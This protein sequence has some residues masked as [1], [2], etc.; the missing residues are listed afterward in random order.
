VGVHPSR[1]LR[2]AKCGDVFESR[3]GLSNHKRVVTGCG[4]CPDAALPL[5]LGCNRCDWKCA[6]KDILVAHYEL[7]HAVG[8]YEGQRTA[9]GNDADSGDDAHYG[10]ENLDDNDPDDVSLSVTEDDDPHVFNDRDDDDARDDVSLSVAEKDDPHVFYDLDDDD[11]DDN[12]VSG[13]VDN[14]FYV[15]DD[16]DAVGDL[17]LQ[18]KRMATPVGAT[19]DDVAAATFSDKSGDYDRKMKDPLTFLPSQRDELRLMNLVV[20]KNLPDNYYDE[21]LGVIKNMETDPRDGLLRSSKLVIKDVLSRNEQG[22]SANTIVC[23]LEAPIGGQTT[24]EFGWTGIIDNLKQMLSDP[25]LLGQCVGD[26]KL[27]LHAEDP[28]GENETVSEMNQAH[29]WR[30][31]EEACCHDD[32]KTILGVVT[33]FI[34]GTHCDEHGRIKLVPIIMMCGNYPKKLNRKSDFMRCLGYLPSGI[35]FSSA[36]A[37]AV[38]QKKVLLKLKHACLAA[39]FDEMKGPSDRRMFLLHINGELYRVV[40]VVSFFINDTA[41]ADELTAHYSTSD[42]ENP[43]RF[44]QVRKADRHE[45]KLGEPRLERDMQALVMGAK[46]IIDAHVPGKQDGAGAA[47]ETLKGVSLQAIDNAFWGVFFGMTGGRGIYGALPIEVLHQLEK[48]LMKYWHECVIITVRNEGGDDLVSKLDCRA[49]QLDPFMRH[50][51][52]RGI[53]SKSFPRGASDVPKLSAQE[54]PAVVLMIIACLG[55]VGEFL[56]KEVARRWT[57]LGWELLVLRDYLMAEDWTKQM[58]ENLN[59][60][61]ISVMTNFREVTQKLKN[62]FWR[63][64]KRKK[65]LV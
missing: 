12:S 46:D 40:P 56:P 31:T 17:A 54:M 59:P 61:V 55:D 62:L 10:G 30:R 63:K 13:A 11:A 34:D 6:T 14:A 5:I 60:L 44:C 45:P 52:E 22:L 36:D 48:G 1:F 58:R 51:S 28:V 4:G 27:L 50:Q 18:I 42:V 32:P 65:N 9:P 26:H 19:F 39:M 25:L 16:D 29:W 33:F 24:Y 8:V 2:C 53:K 37:Q 64:K 43:C 21:L 35:E 7:D 41:E 47:R 49:R 20:G 23:Q 57:S 15:S 3:K 38:A